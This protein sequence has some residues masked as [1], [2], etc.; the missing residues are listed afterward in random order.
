MSKE[1]KLSFVLLAIFS[2]IIMAWKTLIAFFG[3]TGINLVAI[4]AISVVLFLLVIKNK[5]TRSR[6][7]DMFVIACVLLVMELVFYFPIEFGVE[8]YK[9]IKGFLH[10]QNVITFISILFFVYIGFRFILEYLN[11]RLG[12]IEFILGNKSINRQAKEKKSKSLENGSLEEKPNNVQ[13]PAITYQAEEYKDIETS[14][15]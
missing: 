9:V 7:I 15:E 5:E 4:L 14:E 3:G 8:K 13:E 11:K 1:L 2:G 10:Y 6:I 12:F